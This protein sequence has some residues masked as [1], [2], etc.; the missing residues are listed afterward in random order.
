MTAGADWDDVVDNAAVQRLEYFLVDNRPSNAR[1]NAYRTASS[2]S[3]VAEFDPD[4]GALYNAEHAWRGAYCAGPIG[5][6]PWGTRYAVNVEFLARALGA[7]PV[8]NVNDVVVVSAGPDRVVDTQFDI[9]GA[10]RAK[11]RAVRLVWRDP[12]SLKVCGFCGVR[13]APRCVGPRMREC[14]RSPYEVRSATRG[15]TLAPRLLKVGRGE[16]PQRTERMRCAPGNQERGMSLVEATI[17]LM[18]LAIL[19]SVLAPSIGDYVND[20]RQV[21]AKEDLEVLGLSVAR[22][23]RDTGLPFP[24]RTAGAAPSKASTNRVDLLVS[25]G[26][27]PTITAGTGVAAAA[28]GYLIQNAV[29]WNDPVGAEVELATDHLISNANAYTV[30]TFPAPAG[31]VPGLGWRGGYMSN[32]LDPI[33]GACDTRARRCG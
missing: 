11:R 12:L 30:V 6:D 10:T 14:G 5:P 2:M 18:V 33:P 4:S 16:V 27:L 7:G 3:V 20:A 17:I 13:E 19:T 29:E 15:C 25:E 21:K 22:L 8:G 32:S 26:Q 31:P 23:V 1:A 24:V 9:D 28:A